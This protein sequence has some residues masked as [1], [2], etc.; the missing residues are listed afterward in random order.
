M[1]YYNK[2]LCVTYDELTGGDNPIFKVGT[3]KSLQYR[4]RVRLAKRGGGEGA[5][6]LY[7]YSSLPDKYKQKFVAKYGEP[8]RVM[9]EERLKSQ[10]VMDDAA[11]AFYEAYEYDL[12][13]V[14]THLKEEVVAEYTLNASVLNAL[15]QA[16]QRMGV[17]TRMRGN[18][19]RDLWPSVQDLCERLREVFE[20]TLPAGL[21][22]LK[23]KI[24][25]YKRDGYVALV[26]GKLGNSNTIKITEEGQELLVALKRSK[27]PVYTDK[28]IFEEFN[29]RAEAKG[30]KL[31]K[32][33]SGLRAWF[34]RADIVQLWY[35]AVHGEQAA[36]LRF[37]RRHL[38]K[39]PEFRDTLWYGDGTRL[40]L[41][42]RDDAGNR[43]TL[44][45]YEIV[46][47]A[48]EV[49]LGYH[50]S[51]REDYDAQYH[52]LRMA[53]GMSGHK[54]LEIV[55]D[56]QGGH[57]KLTTQGIFSKVA[58]MHRPTAPYNGRSKT[59]ESI[60]GRF[61]SEVLH[62]RWY[63]T[64]QNITAKKDSSRPDLEFVKAN[65]D[66]LPTRAEL[67]AE[68]AKAREEWNTLPHPKTG[69]ARIEMYQS[70]ENPMTPVVGQYDM[71]D[72]FW[73]KTEKPSTFTA[74]GIKVTIHKREHTY[75]VMAEAGKPDLVWR[76]KH[77]GEQFYVQYDPCD[78]TSVRLITLDGRF[79]RIARP[80]IVIARAHAEQTDADKAFIRQMQEATAQERV[81]R[82]VAARHI[83]EKHGVLPEQNG[84]VSPQ[85][86]ALPKEQQEELRRRTALHRLTPNQPARQSYGQRVKLESNTDWAD[87]LMPTAEES[88]RKALSKM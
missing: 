69:Q 8:E 59:I 18:P 83:E 15:I 34:K 39:L 71:V 29:R 85:P 84:L 5:C 47:A 10:L 75:E 52:A 42:Y 25:K 56:N 46:D 61:Q 41:Y 26:S 49:L 9:R 30:W 31:L 57:K 11:R 21:A 81:E 27:V 77:T 48:T 16:H 78:M 14:Q 87:V 35:D 1:E 51:E 17:E 40:N 68:Y 32:S 3:L 20:H 24:S 13:G 6:A 38:T 73:L 37:D 4:E 45:V 70:Q 23:D 86:L 55:T 80:P 33:L 74:S 60:F 66:Q 58:V 82:L 53:I 79:E 65:T 72:M 54:P 22:R 44:Q 67:L 43:C 62:Q 64:G 76:R 7:V 50:I 12:N 19:R 28:Q 2:E 36:R 88:Y 63:F